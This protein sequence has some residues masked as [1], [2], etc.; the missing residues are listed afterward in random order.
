[1]TSDTYRR[2]ATRLIVV[3]FSSAAWPAAHAGAPGAAPAV[4]GPASA[5]TYVIRSLGVNAMPAGVDSRGEIALTVRQHRAPM[6]PAIYHH[7]VFTKLAE[8][9][10]VEAF[11]RRGDAAGYAAEELVF[12]PQGGDEVV[13]PPPKGMHG[14]N[15]TAV[16]DERLVVGT[17][18]L[19][20]VATG[21]FSW[22][23]TDGTRDLGFLVEGGTT[24]RPTAVNDRGQIAGYGDDTDGQY[25]AF[26]HQ[27]GH[28]HLLP[29]LSGMIGCEA[30]DINEKGDV[31]GNC[32]DP[33]FR[34]H[35][36]LWHDKQPADLAPGATYGEYS[37]DLLINDQGVIVGN[38]DD[39]GAGFEVALFTPDGPVALDTLVR[40]IHEWR[41]TSVEGIN[42]QGE[43]VGTG[44]HEGVETDAQKV[45]RLMPVQ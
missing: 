21:C 32:Y 6:Y 37:G 39:G 41:L 34:F 19:T 13:I 27:H 2:L 29:R 30:T 1:M 33:S 18:V 40:N 3:A 22:T 16:N 8:A 14:M 36:V 20:R 28:F 35:P 7:G 4:A 5:P 26:I 25:V 45:F 9:G 44:K 38:L 15:A 23:P 31:V 42:D 11:S 43:I 12:W 10:V 17:F 24:C